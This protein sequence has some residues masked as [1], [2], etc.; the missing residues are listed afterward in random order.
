MMAFTHGGRNGCGQKHNK[1]SQ[2]RACESRRRRT[3]PNAVRAAADA[4]GPTHVS[5]VLDQW[6]WRNEIDH[7]AWL[8]E[9]LMEEEDSEERAWA[10]I[11]ELNEYWDGEES[12]R[13]AARTRFERLLPFA[14]QQN[15][16]I[17][18]GRL[19]GRRRS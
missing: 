16:L 8:G 19:G 13:T 11:E 5:E 9:I 7:I 2:A 17:H 6:T 1:V 14:R 3:P 10:R 18:E 4:S 12:P 15:Q